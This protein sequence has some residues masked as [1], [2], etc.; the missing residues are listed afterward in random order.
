[1]AVY[2]NEYA[3][4]TCYVRQSMPLLFWFVNSMPVTALPERYNASS[5]NEPPADGTGANSTL[6]ILALEETNNSVILC[7]IDITGRI[8][9]N[10]FNTSASLLVQG[11]L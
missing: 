6:R 4:F 1:M 9:R 11:I 10:Y 8:D 2:L 5:S 3:Q 7:A